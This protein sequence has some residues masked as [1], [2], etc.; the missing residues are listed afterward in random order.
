[1]LVETQKDLIGQVVTL[2]LISGQE[3]IG[4][5]VSKDDKQYALKKPRTPMR[6]E[7]GKGFALSPIMATVDPNES[8][9]FERHTV[10]C[11]ALTG[12]QFSQ[13]YQQS[14]SGIITPAKPNFTA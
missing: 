2:L 10:A 5:L 7:D 12:S 9:I 14:T 11:V 4:T 6:S 1:M 3:V 8:A 13:A